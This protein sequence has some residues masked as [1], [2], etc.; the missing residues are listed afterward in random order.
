MGA[1][2]LRIDANIGAACLALGTSTISGDTGASSGAFCWLAGSI[3]PTTMGVVGLCVDASV[4]TDRC[5]SR[6]G[7]GSSETDLS[8]GAGRFAFT[9]AFVY[10]SVAVV[11]DSV[12]FFSFGQDLTFAGR[13]STI[14]RVAGSQ[15]ALAVSNVTSGCRAGIALFFLGRDTN[16][17]F[18]FFVDQAI[19]VIVNSVVAKVAPAFTL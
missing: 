13:P 2:G 12:A 3:A 6:A 11:V 19:T 9:A 1:V 8:V 15:A 4:V 10:L 5:S 14:F 18:V 7:T 16:T 17:I